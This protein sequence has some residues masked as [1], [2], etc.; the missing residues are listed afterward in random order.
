ML[1]ACPPLLAPCWLAS[2]VPLVC[3]DH[4]DNQDS[5]SPAG[6]VVGVH[7]WEV[8]GVHWEESAGGG[9]PPPQP[10][11]T[12]HHPTHEVPGRLE[13]N[14]RA[15]TPLAGHRAEFQQPSL[16]KSC[17]WP[18][19]LVH[20]RDCTKS[21]NPVRSETSGTTVALLKHRS[22]TTL[23]TSTCQPSHGLPS[24]RVHDTTGIS[25]DDTQ[26]SQVV[27]GSRIAKVN[28]MPVS[29]TILAN[30]CNPDTLAI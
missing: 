30:T 18:S 7:S 21:C 11:L 28:R 2:M 9:R 29:C 16:P 27:A 14:Q 4:A 10:K 15:Q 19:A 6:G 8:E 3:R 5:L 1:E 25:G 26:S 23:H 17:L 24:V 13:L 22:R 20:K 12:R